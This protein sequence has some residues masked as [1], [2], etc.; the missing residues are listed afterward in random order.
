MHDFD[1]TSEWSV[2]ETDAHTFPPR[3]HGHVRW[4]N[5]VYHYWYRARVNEW[6]MGVHHNKPVYNARCDI[7]EYDGKQVF[8]HHVTCDVHIMAPQIPALL[9][10]SLSMFVASLTSTTT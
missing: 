1:T 7:N 9:N 10:N 2:T 5:Q 3:G 8:H 4:R 6:Y